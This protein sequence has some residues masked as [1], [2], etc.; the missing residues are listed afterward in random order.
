MQGVRPIDVQPSRS[1]RR[2][3]LAGVLA[4]LCATPLGAQAA[5]SCPAGPFGHPVPPDAQITHIDNALPR[6]AF[7]QNGQLNANVE[8]PVWKDGSLYFSE[9]GAG[10]NPP[11]SRILRYT[12]DGPGVVFAAT[13]GTN[14]LATDANGRLHGASHKVGGIVRFGAGGEETV[15]VKGYQGVRFNSPNDLTFRSDGTLYFTDPTWQAPNPPPQAKT[16]VYR[17][18]AGSHKA[19]VI[20]ADREQ[21]NGITLSPNEKT[22]YLSSL[23]GL[24]KY[25]VAADGTV[26]A[27]KR[28]ASQIGG[29]DGMVVDCAGNL[30]VTS[31]DVIILDPSGQEIGRLKMP[32]GAGSV[33]NVAFGGAKRKTLYI[34]AMG[35]GSGRGVFKVDLKVPGLPY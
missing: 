4:A 5:W 12:G 11:P 34:T 1:R 32:A 30:Y 17:V 7:N 2:L 10:A 28:F 15:V 31:T 35:Q 22:L 18:P 21:P 33:T 23:S 29:A 6:D 27:P 8:G 13:A 26:G 25:A 19:Q 14:G 3:G 20:D 24:Y 16:R 9:F